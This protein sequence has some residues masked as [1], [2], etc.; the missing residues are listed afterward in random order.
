MTAMP[1]CPDWLKVLVTMETLSVHCGLYK[2]SCTLKVNR[3]GKISLLSMNTKY[4]KE[5]TNKF[6]IVSD[7]F[8]EYF[9][10]VNRKELY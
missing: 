9:E 6:I 10:I 1:S 5:K 7:G 4:I 8:Y 3:H 2:T